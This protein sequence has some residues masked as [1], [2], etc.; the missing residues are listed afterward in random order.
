MRG[1][2]LGTYTTTFKDGTVSG[3]LLVER[4][5]VDNI[6]GVCVQPFNVGLNNLPVKI[7][8]TLLVKKFLF[9]IMVSPDIHGLKICLSF[10]GCYE[11]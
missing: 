5:D 2:V 10:R 11:C 9:L 6:K 1:K 4:T 8:V 7:S 3:V